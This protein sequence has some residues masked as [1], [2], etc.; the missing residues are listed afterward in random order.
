MQ[1]EI[2]CIRHY[3]PLYQN[4]SFFKHT[5]RITQLILLTL[6]TIKLFGKSANKNGHGNNNIYE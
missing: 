2:F 4:V 1:R 6:S 3:G 5:L